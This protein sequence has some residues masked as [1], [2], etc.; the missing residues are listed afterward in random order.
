MELC[1]RAGGL[2]PTNK[3]SLRD[4]ITYGGET[5]AVLADPRAE[6]DPALATRVYAL[7]AIEPSDVF[8]IASQ[9]GGN[10]SIVEMALHAS[11]VGHTVIAVT[12]LAHSGAIT[13]RHA[14]GKR[15]FE[16]ADI[17][18]DNGAPFGDAPLRLPAG[19]SVCAVSSIGNALIAQMLTAE[20][21]ARLLATGHRPPVY[22]SANVEGG[23][24][25]NDV[26][27][28]AY[29]GRVRRSAF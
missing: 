7:A 9:S 13:S 20:T 26:L 5:P 8:V 4:V 22:L 10:G 25:H 16:V 19:D 17:V 2:V 28:A 15:L 6:R 12:S 11:R 14:S 21:A 18:I 27:E 29:A 1:G 3:L 23:D 24:A